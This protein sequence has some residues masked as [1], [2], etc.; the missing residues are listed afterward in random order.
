VMSDSP[1]TTSTVSSTDRWREGC[2]ST[3]IGAT[4]APWPL[5]GGEQKRVRSN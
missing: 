1:G 4:M 5:R 3:P 2:S